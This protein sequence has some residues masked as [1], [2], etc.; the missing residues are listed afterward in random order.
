MTLI[1]MTDKGLYCSI[2]KFYIDPYR[3]VET[4]LI[5]HAHADHAKPGSENYITNTLGIP[6][7]KKRLG[8]MIKIQG[9]E[10]GELKEI[11]DVKIS[12]QKDDFGIK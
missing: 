4:A 8:S 7:L 11:N 9:L 5:T 10:Y 2:G 3:G 1:S 6:I 12:S